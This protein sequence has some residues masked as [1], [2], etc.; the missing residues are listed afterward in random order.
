MIKQL[1][2]QWFFVGIAVMILVSFALPAVGL[3]LRQYKVLNIGIFLAFFITGLTLETSSLVD[4]LKNG[5]V[6]VAALVSSLFVF[7]GI[8]YFLG[9]LA[10]RSWPDFS[11]GALIIGVAPV[12]VAS[13]TVMTS[14]ALGNVPLSLFICV[15]CNFVSILTIPFMLNLFLQFGDTVI[16]LPVIQMLTGLTIKVLIPTLIGQLLRPKLK[17]IITPYGKQFSIFN[18]AIVLLIILNAVSS[19]TGQLLKVGPVLA[20]VFLFMVGLHT[21]ILGMN[22]GLSRFL[23]LDRPS[24]AAFTIHTSQKTLTISYLVWAGYFATDYPMALIP[25]IAY[26]LTQMIMDTIIAHRFR[27]KAEAAGKA[28]N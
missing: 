12:T 14:I 6:L 7:P 4:Q 25:P 5:R 17:R 9:Q 27:R 3:F 28:G 24:L 16:E 18:Q 22:Y 10:F 8:A 13:G 1:K 11:I 23:K 15:L 26:H 19:S 2:K 20:L 21:L